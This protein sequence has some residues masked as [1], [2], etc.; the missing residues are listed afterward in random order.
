MKQFYIRS[1]ILYISILYIFQAIG[2]DRGHNYIKA[3][4]P[5]Q[6]FAEESAIDENKSLVTIQYF[7][8]LGMPRET[9]RKNFTGGNT[10]LITYT[11]YN[12]RGLP[13]REWNPAPVSGNNGNFVTVQ[14]LQNVLSGVYPN[15]THPFSE[16]FYENAMLNRP[17]EEYGPGKDWRVNGGHARR[18]EYLTNTSAGELAAP[19]YYEEN[20]VLYKQ[21]NYAPGTLYVT[22]SADEDGNP[23]YSFTDKQGRLVMFR[24]MNGTTASSTCHVYDKKGNRVF[25][26]SPKASDMLRTNS[27]WDAD[28]EVLRESAYVYRFDGLGRCVERRF[29]GTDWVKTVYDKMSYPV[30]SQDG[31][32]RAKGEWTFNIPDRMNRQVLSGICRN[33]TLPDIAGKAVYAEWNGSENSF[34]GTGY[35]LPADISLTGVQLLTVS[36]YDGYSFKKLMAD[37]TAYAYNIPEGIPDT[38]HGTDGST[39]EHLGMLTG[40]WDRILDSESGGFLK[41][42]FYYDYEG[43]VIQ[44]AA[45]NHLGGMDIE[46]TEYNF[47]GQPVKKIHTQN[48]TSMILRNAPQTS[49]KQSHTEVYTYEYDGAGR[50]TITKHSID[51]QPERTISS[52]TYDNLGRL[53]QRKPGNLAAETYSYNIR[54]WIYS[55]R[56]GNH[57]WQVNAY[58]S[59]PFCSDGPVYYNGNIT[60]S[61][62]ISFTRNSSGKAQAVT[63]QMTYRYDGLNR[64]TKAELTNPR[65]VFSYFDEEFFYDLNGNITR[66]NR[67]WK[68]SREDAIVF[69]YK[70]NQINWVRDEGNDRYLSELPQITQGV[71]MPGLAYDANGNRIKDLS[72]GIQSVSFNLLNLPSEF[73]FGGHDRIGISYAADGRKL[74]VSKSWRNTRLLSP[75]LDRD[76]LQEFPGELE[77]DSL[78]TTPVIGSESLHYVNNFTYKP[79][80]VLDR[81]C[82][83]GGFITYDEGTKAYVYHYYYRDHLGSNVM[84]LNENG[85]REQ[86]TDYYP[87]G[88][89]TSLYGPLATDN[90]LHLNMEFESILGLHLYDNGARWR[91][92]L[93]NRFISI[94]PLCEQYYH[95]SPYAYAANN[96]LKFADR[97]GK[98]FESAWDF[99]SLSIGVNS[100]I[101]NIKTKNIGGAIVDGIGIMA[102]AMALALPGIPGGAGAGIKALRGADK[103]V[104]TAKTIN[105]TS[106]NSQKA[107]FIG[108]TDG[109]IID[110]KTTQKGSYTHPDGSRTDILQDKTHFDKKT[111]INHGTS[112]THKSYSNKLPD[113]TVKTGISNKD[114]HVPTYEEIERIKNGTAIKTK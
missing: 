90:R 98:W 71:Y 93:Y 50:P 104:D 26:L 111:Q 25:V 63:K 53:S 31:N 78:E 91:D 62:I 13:C 57:F 30:F 36:F 6:P 110:T 9:V 15:E 32:Q 58:T 112:H 45:N 77:K 100:L 24:Q 40:K 99:T 51:G 76:S 47:R 84:I 29:P 27:S 94:D 34:Q 97:N 23:S 7:D 82:F 65:S 1:L 3:I 14:H 70:G 80:S 48:I 68:D 73:S 20:G 92:P 11:E 21:G 107:R 54:G 52:L 17:R 72:R 95:L 5:L 44:S 83:D 67:H 28:F 86:V 12:E 8:G 41:T 16:T 105:K 56:A 101:D 35:L 33:T 18:T 64:M 42:V 61:T 102:D 109:K 49:G 114:T 108:D 46:S 55:I 79:F 113:G 81:I 59:N 75:V 74:A 38:R 106:Q 10:D 39:G 19:Y 88:I 43:R 89:P 60:A 85:T 96:P 66:I 2:Q 4:E 103:A 87:S 69:T 22:L 37:R